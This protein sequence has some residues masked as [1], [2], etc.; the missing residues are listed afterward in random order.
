MYGKAKPWISV[1]GSTR[2]LAVIFPVYKSERV[3]DPFLGARV[4]R[5]TGADVY[6]SH[7]CR[8]SVKFYVLI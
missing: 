8:V 6:F 2:R 7:Y 1:L 3:Y 4:G 5:R